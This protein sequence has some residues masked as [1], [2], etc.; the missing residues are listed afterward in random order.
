MANPDDYVSRLEAFRVAIGEGAGA[1]AWRIEYMFESLR[2]EC[3]FG[4]TADTLAWYESQVLEN[5]MRSH[6]IPLLE[7]RQW[8]IDPETGSLVHDSGEFFRVDGIRTI[9]SPTREV[10]RGWDQ[11]ILTQ[12]GFD[13]G[14]L[15]ILRQ[16]FKGIPHYLVEAKAEPG[17]YRIVQI[18]ST[19]QA[20]FSNLKRAHRGKAPAYAEYFT[21]PATH[22]GTVIIDQWMSED[23][24]RLNSKRNKTMLVEIPEGQALELISPRF[25]WV[26]LFQLKELLRTQNAIVAPHIRGVLAVV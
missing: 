25:R 1:A 13:G 4:T 22:N 24:G 11:P 10:E 18:T 5:Q 6:V 9:A 23:G 15:G 19:V 26:S 17:N 20:T 8:S 12:V 16:R 21:D 14:I 2:D 7:C 3:L